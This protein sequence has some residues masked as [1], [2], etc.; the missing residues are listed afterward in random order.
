MGIGID[1]KVDYAFKMLFGM[2]RNRDILA[3]FVNAVL[4]RSDG[5][6][7][8]ELELLDPFNSKEIADDKLSIVDVK[9]RDQLGRQ[10][11]I[12]MQLV[13]QGFFRQR[14]LYYGARLH[15]QQL[16]EGENYGQLSPT[17]CICIVNARL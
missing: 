13:P 9:A 17:I 7:I 8:T 12:E 15:A 6:W 16:C 14:M 2:E 1:P 10:F 11:L 4:E 5:T 3:D